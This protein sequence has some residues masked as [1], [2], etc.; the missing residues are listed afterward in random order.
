MKYLTLPL[1]LLTS[2]FVRGQHVGKFLPEMIHPTERFLFY[3]HGGAVT[4]K[5]NNAITDAA[6]EWGPYEY[7]NILDTLRKKG[8]NVIS[9]NRKEGVDDSVYIRK[10]LMQIDTLLSKGVKAKN[11]LV[12]GASAGWVITLGVSAQLPNGNVN[13][14]MMGGCWPDTYKDFLGHRLHG[15]ILSIY[16]RTDPHQSCLKIFEGKKSLR[17]HREIVLNTG[18]SHGFIYKGF[19]EWVDPVVQWGKREP[20]GEL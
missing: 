1:L 18:L 20:L 19:R 3:Q 16:E 13:Y 15:R 14:V 10:I 4:A 7:L 2:L 6:P 5:G 9:E 11:I 8:F 17:A 12:V